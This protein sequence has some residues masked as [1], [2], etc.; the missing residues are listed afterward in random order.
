MSTPL[1]DLPNLKKQ[2]SP[3]YEEKENQIVTEILN[4]IDNN[5]ENINMDV[6]PEQQQQQEQYFEPEPQYL[7]PE[8][9]Y[10]EPE[11]PY[12]EPEQPYLEHEPLRVN[13]TN[14]QEQMIIEQ[15]NVLDK[16]AISNKKMEY[17]LDKSINEDNFITKAISLVKQPTIVAVVV[18][19]VSLPYIDKIMSGFI[20][21]KEVLAKYST[22]ILILL[23]SIFGGGL[24][25]GINKSIV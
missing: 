13:E 15:Q 3:A 12:L 8:Q 25:F 11:Q 6:M 1:S 23:K 22:L 18:A 24:Y 10:L 20:S 21:R 16:Q 4:E 5:R 14:T 19:I 9:P 7:E 2:N 17:S